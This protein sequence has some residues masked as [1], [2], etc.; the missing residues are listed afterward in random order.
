ML[1]RSISGVRGIVETHL[2][3]ETFLQ[4]LRA[5]HDI[6][7]D[8]VIY[9]GRDSRQ[10]GEELMD[11]AFEEFQNLGRDVIHC[12][13]VP[14]PT[15]QYIVKNT[16]GVGGIVITASHNPTQWNG[17]KFVREDGIFFHPDE[18]KKLF[19]LV[20]KKPK[21]KSVK[22][23]G[24]IWQDYNVIQ[25]HAFSIVALSCIDA[26]KIQQRKFKVAVDAVNGGAAIALPMLLETLGCEV[27][28]IY[29]EPSGEFVRGTE[30]I[31]ENLV[32]LCNSVQQLNADVGMAVDP[33][34]DRLAIVDENGAPLGEE[35]TL[36]LAAD[37]YLNYT[38]SSEALVTN[39]STTLA[40]D[41][42]AEKHG[43]QVIR[44]PIGE[45]N[46]VNEMEKSGANLG[47][48]GNGG[49]ILRESHLGRDALVG[50]AMVLNRLAQSD[51]P[52]SQIFAEY[53]QFTIVKDKIKID[54]L[55]YKQ[56]RKR[57]LSIFKNVLV[58]DRD[59][60]KFVWSDKWLHI[61]KSNTEPIMRIYAEGENSIKA[62]ELIS[63]LKSAIS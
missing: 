47:G 27:E 37:G 41:K 30:P 51:Q 10:S 19:A 40:L 13:I 61:R 24:M 11:I 8:G 5:A 44:T 63:T 9:L 33:D 48:E 20:D 52:L 1:I 53:P 17:L 16:E 15:I 23:Q 43:S 50:A 59:G 29:C 42:I 6:F 35:Y 7:A 39:L 32:D 45:I 4:Y 12:G 34:G 38:R 57:A 36:V 31:P 49:I 62:E 21:H 54:K 2:N 60:L 46:V 14:T 3:G 18:C 28:R 55:D 22:N 56:V 25:K 58:D 26:K